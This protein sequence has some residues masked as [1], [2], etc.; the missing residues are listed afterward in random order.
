MILCSTFS[1]RQI[2]RRFPETEVC[3]PFCGCWIVAKD[4]QEKIECICGK[5]FRRTGEKVL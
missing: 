5:T 4:G 2:P 3:C 1:H